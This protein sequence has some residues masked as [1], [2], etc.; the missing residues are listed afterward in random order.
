MSAYLKYGPIDVLIEKD[1][2][3][4]AFTCPLCHNMFFAS[5][6]QGKCGHVVQDHLRQYHRINYP[7][8]T[9]SEY[10]MAPVKVGPRKLL[11]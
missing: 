9:I 8:A 1:S 6:D 10:E 5:G 3:G 7:A 11:V 4:I 2:E